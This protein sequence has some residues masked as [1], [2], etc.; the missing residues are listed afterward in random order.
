[1]K[2]WSCSEKEVIVLDEG[3]VKL[4][5]FKKLP[6]QRGPV[7]P[8]GHAQTCFVPYLLQAPMFVHGFGIHGFFPLR[9]R[10]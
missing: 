6:W 8:F 2:H 5:Y 10:I 7:N 1:M 3:H 9:S 4:T